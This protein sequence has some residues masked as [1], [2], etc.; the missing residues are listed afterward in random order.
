MPG[1]EIWE[2]IVTAIK[3]RIAQNQSTLVFVNSR[4]LCEKITFMINHGNP[5]PIAYAHHGSL[6]RELRYAVEEKLKKGDLKA[7]VATNSL[8]LGI[9]IGALDEV[10]L[11]QSPP[12]IASA[13][14]RLGRAGHRVNATSKGVLFPT[15]AHDILEAGV[16]ARGIAEQDIESARPVE[17]PLDVLSQIIISMTGNGNL[18]HGQPFCHLENQPSFSSSVPG[19]F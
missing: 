13:L 11:V 17:C 4:R 2:P 12:S 19:T 9:D 5:Y 8:E 15:H 10:I 6:S 16:L 7:I 14:Q 1:K 3:S 18:G